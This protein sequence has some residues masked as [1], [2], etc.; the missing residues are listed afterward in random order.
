MIGNEIILRRPLDTGGRDFQ[1]LLQLGV[2]QIG[3]FPMTAA[4]ASATAFLRPYRG[5]K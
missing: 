3:I 1:I 5:L 2:H 4:E